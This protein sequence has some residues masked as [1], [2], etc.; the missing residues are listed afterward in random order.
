MWDDA[1]DQDHDRGDGGEQR[2]GGEP[3]PALRRAAGSAG[4]Q[5]PARRDRRDSQEGECGE[6]EQ[7]IWLGCR[8]G[9]P[10]R[11]GDPEKRA[12]NSSEVKMWVD[13]ISGMV[14]PAFEKVT[15]PQGKAS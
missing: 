2:D 6:G 3:D 10:V 5:R 4:P 8:G 11:R 1:A 7:E 14:M 9:R 15:T 13:P 12:P